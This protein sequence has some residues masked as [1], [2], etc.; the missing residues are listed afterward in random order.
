[1]PERPTLAGSLMTPRTRASEPARCAWAVGDL[2]I[3]Y[4]DREW[5][6]P[7]HR[8]RTLFAFLIL[9]GAQAGLSWETILRR[10]AGYQAAFAGFDPVA[11]ATFTAADVRRLL[12]DPGIIRNRLKI[13]SAVSNAQAFLRVRAE[14]GTFNRYLWGFVGGQTIHCRTA[15]RLTH[16]PESDALSKD[17][18]KRGFTFVGTTICYAYMQAVGLV[19]DHAPGCFRH[20]LLRTPRTIRP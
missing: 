19:N 10:R 15:A 14:Y 12:A 18:K 5:G 11:V 16:S 13:R 4:H 6:V 8:D 17:L 1:M 3:R 2:N 20:D 9:E 7:Q